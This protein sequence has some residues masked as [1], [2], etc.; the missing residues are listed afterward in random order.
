MHTS[1]MKKAALVTVFIALALSTMMC[2]LVVPPATIS[3]PTPIP[4]ATPTPI[5]PADLGDYGDA[6]DGDHNMDTGYYAPAGS[7]FYM[8][9]ASAGVSADFPTFGNDPIPG[10]FTIDVDEFWIG[11]LFGESS[12]ADIP[13]IEDDVNDPL[14]PDGV[15]NLMLSAGRAD[16]DR[17]NGTHNPAANGCS[18]VPPYSIPMNARLMI[19]FGY[20]PLGIWITS[21]T[22]SETM[23]YEGP[24]YWNFL[25]DLNQDGSWDGSDEWIAR[26]VRVSLAPGETVTLISPA[27][28]FPTSGTPWGR[29]KFPLWARSMVTSESVQDA[30][31]TS[32]WDGRGPADG[33]EVGEVEDYF[34]E[35]QPI[36][37]HLPNQEPLQFND[38]GPGDMA[39]FEGL[40]AS[41]ISLGETVNLIPR[42]TE[43]VQILAVSDAVDG[44]PVV[45][46]GLL[47]LHFNDVLPLEVAGWHLEAEIDGDLVLH[48]NPL[49]VPEDAENPRLIF[50]PDPF[51]GGQCQGTGLAAVLSAQMWVIDK[52]G[53][54]ASEMSVFGIWL[55]EALVE[56]DKSNNAGCIQ[57]NPSFKIH[58]SEGSIAFEGDPPWVNVYGEINDDGTFFAEGRGVV[59]RIP[60]IAVTFEGVIDAEGLNGDYTMGAE[61]GLPGGDPV[62]YTI[63]GTLQWSPEAEEEEEAAPEPLSAG[64]LEAIDSFIQVFNQAFEDTDPEPLFQLL[65]PAVI[66]RYGAEAC[67]VYFETIIETPTEIEFVDAARIGA[68]DWDQDGAITPVDFAYAVTVNFSA[69]GDTSELDLHLTLPGDDSVRWFTDCGDPLP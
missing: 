2:D 44:G 61:G 4:T 23:T 55:L 31:G 30:L 46:I 26:D 5:P 60:D 51:E 3:P 52:L 56:E 29:L 41:R 1:K 68:W 21:I 19:M 48:I 69:M 22:A 66:D 20:P 14:D 15:S 53:P 36:G 35:W 42:D 64:V 25:F 8:T 47:D 32:S 27:F 57:L 50:L 18:P 10:P 38:C 24:I 63:T 9:Y 65:N 12:A 37:Q 62:I 28:R 11:P 13:S 16:C 43:S 45:N 49:Q 7:P 40:P 67:Q 59:K 39:A 17:E 58:I 6:P 54:E 34:V 33:F